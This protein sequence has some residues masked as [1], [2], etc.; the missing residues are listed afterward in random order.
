MNVGFLSA[1]RPPVVLTAQQ[2]R[3]FACVANA[4]AGTFRVPPGPSAAALN[5]AL[6]GCMLSTTS[7]DSFS[8]AAG[9]ISASES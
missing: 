1:P 9:R 4:A 6:H 5:T 7:A 2:S 3:A 8:R